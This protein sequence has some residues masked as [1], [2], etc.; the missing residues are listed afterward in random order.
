[1][2]GTWARPAQPLP[3]NLAV[4]IRTCTYLGT[5]LALVRSGTARLG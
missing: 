2:P 4:C 1:M 3:V 5:Y